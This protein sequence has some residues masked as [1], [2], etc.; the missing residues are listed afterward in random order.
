MYKA[1]KA[2]DKTVRAI[3]KTVKAIC[4]DGGE[5]GGSQGLEL[6][7]LPRALLLLFHE[8]ACVSVYIDMCVHTYK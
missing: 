2:I 7:L 6:R 1:V 4:S 5:G 8:C 3:H